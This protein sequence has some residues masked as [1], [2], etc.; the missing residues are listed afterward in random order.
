MRNAPTPAA[1]RCSSRRRR[2]C[3]TCN[4]K[5]QKHLREIRKFLL[6]AAATEETACLLG[7]REAADCS[8]VFCCSGARLSLDPELWQS[9][10]R[11]CPTRPLLC[12]IASDG[13]RA[14]VRV[15]CPGSAGFDVDDKYEIYNT[16]VHVQASS[17]EVFTIW[18]PTAI[19]TTST[20]V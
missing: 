5:P 18:W 9:V 11:R 13:R 6:S 16:S 8:Q 17:A 2:S 3:S 15:S 14:A 4:T 20:T 19:N 1:H 12:D 7:E 10:G